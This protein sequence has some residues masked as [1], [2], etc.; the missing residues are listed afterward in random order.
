M[1]SLKKWLTNLMEGM[2]LAFIHPI[3]NSVPPKIGMH[4]YRD[5]AFKG[6]HSL[7]NS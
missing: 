5:K 1:K 2:A 6:N 7:F 4:S 3:N